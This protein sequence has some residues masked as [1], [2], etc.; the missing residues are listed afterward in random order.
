MIATKFLD[1][2]SGIEDYIESDSCPSNIRLEMSN[3]DLSKDIQRNHAAVIVHSYIK[4][5]LGLKDIV[6]QETKNSR[7]QPNSHD[8]NPYELKDIYDCRKCVNAIVQV[9]LRRIMKEKYIFSD[10]SRMFGNF[11][12]LSDEEVKD[13]IS[14]VRRLLV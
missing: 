9:Y 3:L 6:F 2:L 10:K 14:A 4:N 11:E 13:I 1:L 7:F 5:A 12:I 8:I